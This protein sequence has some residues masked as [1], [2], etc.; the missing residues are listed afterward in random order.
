MEL[1]SFY[2]NVLQLHCC[3]D[4]GT[5]LGIQSEALLYVLPQ[6]TTYS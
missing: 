3:I 1:E 2:V 4:T 5:A 6:N